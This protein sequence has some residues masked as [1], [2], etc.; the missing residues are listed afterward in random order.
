MSSNKFNL[1][2]Q[3][4]RVLEKLNQ[5]SMENEAIYSVDISDCISN[6]MII[7]TLYNSPDISLYMTFTKFGEDLCYRFLYHIKTSVSGKMKNIDSV[8]TLIKEFEHE[9]VYADKVNV[10]PESGS[11]FVDILRK[12]K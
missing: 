2:L 6:S 5:I 9:F 1:G 10:I 8:M 7:G 11:I 12:K 3:T 4:R